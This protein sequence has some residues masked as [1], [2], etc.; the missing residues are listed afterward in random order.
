MLLIFIFCWFI[1]VKVLQMFWEFLLYFFLVHKKQNNC[2]MVENQSKAL[3]AQQ[4]ETSC[5]TGTSNESSTWRNNFGYFSRLFLDFCFRFGF[6]FFFLVSSHGFFDVFFCLWV[7]ERAFRHS[8]YLS[9]AA[10]IFGIPF[11]YLASRIEP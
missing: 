3:E 9:D 5:R 2:I 4:T 10:P 8:K 11:R 6:V 7:K 1:I